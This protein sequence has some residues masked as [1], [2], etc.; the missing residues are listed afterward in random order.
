MEGATPFARMESMV[1]YAHLTTPHDPTRYYHMRDYLLM[2]ASVPGGRAAPSTAP[3]AAQPD[4]EIRAG[5]SPCHSAADH[6]PSRL[7]R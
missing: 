1:R 4:P 6:G 7:C 3:P 2:L 5:G